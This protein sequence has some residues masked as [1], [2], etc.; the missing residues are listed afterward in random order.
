MSCRESLGKICAAA[1]AM[2]WIAAP[3]EADP[4]ISGASGSVT[5][6]ST[7]TITGSGF[8]AKPTAAP[9]VWD[10]AST[11]TLLTDNG[12]WSGAWPNRGS[13]MS[14]ITQYHTPFRGIALPHSHITRY[15]AGAHGLLNEGYDAGYNVMFWRTLNVTSYPIN[16]YLSWY[17]RYDPATLP[18]RTDWNL[19]YFDWSYGGEPYKMGSCSQNNWY[20]NYAPTGVAITSGTSSLQHQMNDDTW[21]YCTPGALQNPDVNGHSIYWISGKNPFNYWMK[22]EVEGTITNQTSGHV[23]MWEDG[24]QKINYVGRTDAWTLGSRSI[25]VGGYSRDWGSTHWRYFADVYLD[26]SMQRVVLANSS[27]LSG[28][29]VIETQIPTA[30]SDTSISATVNLG[31]FTSGTAYLFVYDATGTA[32]PT[33]YSVTVGG[34]TTYTVTP[35]AGANGSI[36]PNTPQTVNSGATVGFTVTP[37]G[38]YTASVGGTCGGTLVGTTYTTSVI[39]AN[40]TVSA[41]FAAI[42]DTTAPSVSISTANPSNVSSNS[43]TVTGTASDAVGVSGCKWRIGSAPNAGNGTACTG[44]TSFSC[45]T[46]GYSQGS[47]TLYVGCYDAAG[48]YG[49]GSISVSFCKKLAV[50]AGLSLVGL[51]ANPPSNATLSFDWSDVTT[52]ADGSSLT[53]DLAN[54]RTYWGT[55]S[56]GPYNTSS[57]ASSQ[58]S[59]G[60]T[61]ANVTYYA[62]VAAESSVN[63]ICNSD[64][65]AEI[66]LFADT[67]PPVLSGLNPSGNY[68]KTAA[69][70]A[71]GVTTNE[72][73]TCRHGSAGSAWSSKTAFSTTG[74]TSHSATLAVWA[75][76]VKRI[77]YQCRDALLNESAESCTTFSVSAKPKVGVF[78]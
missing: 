26:Y 44:T 46:S 48:N 10:D 36:S 77:C 18:L 25:G 12:K 39:T 64:Q 3:V 65:T 43:L 22:Y 15:I 74:S 72:A 34:A 58:I 69:N 78:N 37:S 35:S 66:S 42:T 14:Y 41:T 33:G 59:V 60:P 4:A 11:G 30:W 32:N 13:N 29:T 8:G 61:N 1:L 73:A 27:S 24:V 50:P 63:S 70:V 54:Y 57:S 19:K 52:H 45:S 49:S 7:I 40:C 5:H 51:T 76:L 2:L 23:K 20:I 28:A 56:G 47:N 62:R 16:F 31:A 67:V 17:Q 75:G 71:L 6:G 9:V 68:P 38:G 55:V 21:G 53:G